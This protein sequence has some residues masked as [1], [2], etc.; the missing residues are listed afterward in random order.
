MSTS[1]FRGVGAAVRS[2]PIGRLFLRADPAARQGT[3]FLDEALFPEPPKPVIPADPA[4]LPQ[5]VP[6]GQRRRRRQP[7]RRRGRGSTII[8]STLGGTSPRQPNQLG[9][10][11]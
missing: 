3:R 5:P 4:P 8:T 7:T 9:G 1:S 2:K 10:V 11:G 6:E